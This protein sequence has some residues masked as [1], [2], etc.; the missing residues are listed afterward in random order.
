MNEKAINIPQKQ[1]EEVF[2]EEKTVKLSCLSETHSV[3]LHM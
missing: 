2:W 3:N 1:N